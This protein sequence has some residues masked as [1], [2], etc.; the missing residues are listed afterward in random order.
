MK[1]YDT[2]R[3][4]V[5]QFHPGETVTIYTC[6]ITP[7]DSE[8]VGHAA[9]YLAYDVLQRRLIDSGRKCRVV[10]NVTDVDDDILKRSRE[11]GVFYLDL[12]AE[13]MAR[14]D[15]NMT[16]L[17]LLPVESEPR[18]TGAIPDILSFVDTL[19]EQGQAYQAADAVYFDVSTSKEFGQLS[20]LNRG[21][22]LKLA[23]ENGGR[24]DDPA[25]RDPL[26]VV[27][28]QPSAA[29]E[30]WW[31]SR[32]G[33]GRPG[34]HVECAA[35]ATRELGKTID[36]HGGGRDLVFP[37][38]E[39]EAAQAQAV[40]G[41]PLARHWMHTAMV[42]FEGEKMSKSLG[43][44]VFV[45]DLLKESDPAVVR[46]ALLAQHYR[47]DWEWS[48]ELVHAA[49]DRLARWRAAGD[50]DGALD[51]VRNALDNDLDTPA[52]VD[53]IDAAAKAGLGVSSALSLLG[54]TEIGR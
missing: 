17:N 27:L 47:H 13:E 51:E 24:P 35:I 26:D 37:H 46:V 7:Y 41:Q 33:R 18:A 25:K 53:E 10:R 48:A 8:H 50:G 44:L 31:E 54:V 38:H 32:W 15:A 9:T 16:S 28:W 20:G 30:P 19:L 12:A 6:G 5:V 52:A 23:A 4:D 36:V 42:A 3:R 22:M 40:T 45:S 11:L 14:F 2:A 43:N 34:W 1:L 29:G 21:E 49:S 39:C